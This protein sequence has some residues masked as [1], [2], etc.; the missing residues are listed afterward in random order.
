MGE[1]TV[2]LPVKGASR[3]AVLAAMSASRAQDAKWRDARTWSLVYHA[4]DEL[5]RLLTDAYTMFFSE[6]G[7]NP[8]A[9]PSLKRFESEVVSMTAGLLGGDDQ[10]VGNMTSGGSESLLMAV[11]T[12]RDLAR[13]ERPDVDEPEMVLPDSA[14]PALLKA[15]HYFGVKPVRV[16][17]RADFRADVEAMA[18]AITPDT[19]LLVGSAPS[20]P[21]GV[22]DPI[23]DIGLLAAERGLSFH[24]DSCLGG[25]LLPFAR[26]LGHAIPDF[27]LRVPGVTS[28]S[29]D[30]HKYGFAAKGASV[31]LYRN[32]RIRR[33]QYFTFADWSGGLYASPTMTGTRP[34]GAI[35]AAWAVLNYLGEEGY[36]RLTETT[37]RT[38]EALMKGINAID[39]LRVLGDPDMSVFAFASDSLD[40]YVVADLMDAR[41]W[42]LDRQQ[43]PS[44]LHLMVTPAHA[45]IVEAF[46]GDLRAVVQ[47]VRS[48]P[49]GSLG[50]G[51]AA[52]YGGIAKMPDR[53]FVHDFLAGV[54]DEWTRV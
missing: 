5:T 51:M 43:M 52:I 54:L 41:G 35:A 36:L 15:A 32:S 17:V 30:V 13:V 11:K 34:G 8:M 24:V 9:F 45:G 42:H 20:Y 2:R 6:N 44:S 47:E 26:R 22:I 27:D 50:G 18:R 10:V 14:H 37:M 4:G 23:A 33:H 46:L 29:A 40:V 19:I 16:P 1:A 49:E 53:T 31:I 21:H 12:A 39:G 3:D 28:I 25:F 48:A 38:T 7:L